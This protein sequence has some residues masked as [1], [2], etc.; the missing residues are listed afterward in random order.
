[1]LGTMLRP[2]ASILA[3]LLAAP[4]L[5][6]QP[7][8]P[9]ASPTE[10]AAP[11]QPEVASLLASA[12]DDYRHRD[13]PGRLDAIREKLERAEKLA[14]D[15]YG[16]LWRLARLYFWLSDDPSIANAE[17]S[18]LGKRGWEYGDRASAV[19]PNGVEGWH[20]AAAG[21]GNYS[22]GIGILTALRQGI[23]G[24]FKD[25]LRKASAIDLKFSDGAILT[26]WGR[27]WYKLPWPKYDA[28]QSEKSLLEALKVNPNNVRAHVYL[29]DLY[30]KE[31]HPKEA[32]EQ[33]EKAVAHAP[34]LYD[35]PEE[36]RWQKVAREELGNTK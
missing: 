3:A 27:F 29:A 18:K 7:S 26:A 35:A 32:R 22:L 21:M 17:K 28:R 12:D 1:M 34:G 5:A 10:G 30:R 24:K 13:E 33:L 23:E 31:D 16:V 2:L 25:R 9:P 4:A 6:Q 11:S 14:P 36:R 8:S 15:D 20:Y 19:N